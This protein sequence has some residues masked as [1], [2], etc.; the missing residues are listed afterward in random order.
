MKFDRNNP[1]RG[2]S[3]KFKA[4]GRYQVTYESDFDFM[5]GRY[6]VNDVTYMPLIDATKNADSPKRKDVD[7]LRRLVKR[8]RLIHITE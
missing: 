7:E 1:L 4:Y 2:F 8:G 3:F 6:Y 5:K